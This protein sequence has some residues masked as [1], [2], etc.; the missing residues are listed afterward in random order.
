[1]DT[2]RAKMIAFGSTESCSLNEYYSAWQFLYDEEVKL[3]VDDY[4]Y[5]D[6]L[7]C[8]GNVTPKE[9]YYD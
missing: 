7:I 5:L 8:D 9:D 1:M 6:K 3:S 2:K 4:F